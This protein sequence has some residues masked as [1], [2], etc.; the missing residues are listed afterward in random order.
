MT[1]MECV[2]QIYEGKI[3][4]DK[5]QRIEKVYGA[6]LPE[7]IQKILSNCDES[8]FFDDGDRILSYQEVI[9]AK[10]DLHIDFARKEIVPIVDC[11]END[12]IV[13]HFKEK[14]WSKFNIVDEIFFKERDTL[15]ELL[16]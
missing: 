15:E 1:K 13:Y 10:E 11:G 9:D 3:D 7:L 8:V 4:K 16:K 5:V 12:F 6:E 2:R 14:K